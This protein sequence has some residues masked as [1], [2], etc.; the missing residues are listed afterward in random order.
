MLA[1]QEPATTRLL[2]SMVGELKL[3]AEARFALTEA[4]LREKCTVQAFFH[5]KDIHGWVR[6]VV[7]YVELLRAFKEWLIANESAAPMVPGVDPRQLQDLVRRAAVPGLEGWALPF[8]FDEVDRWDERTIASVMKRPLPPRLH[9]SLVK[10]LTSLCA[11]L[12]KARSQDRRLIVHPV[13]HPK[14]QALIDAVVEERHA[15]RTD[16]PLGIFD[17]DIDL[18]SSADG[19]RF[20]VI[21]DAEPDRLVVDLPVAGGWKDR[22]MQCTCGA[23]R[24][25]HRAAC[26]EMVVREAVKLEPVLLEAIAAPWERALATLTASPA[27]REEKPASLSI[28]FGGRGI[29]VLLHTIGKKGKKSKGKAIG[30]L[31]EHVLKLSGP[32]RRFAELMALHEAQHRPNTEFF[33]NALLSLAGHPDVRWADDEE[34]SLP[35]VVEAAHV[36]VTETE[37]G[38]RVRV[39]TGTEPLKPEDS[40][41]PATTGFVLVRKVEQ[42]V[43]LFVVPHEVHRVAR[44]LAVNGQDL[45]RE[46][47]PELSRALPRLEG[48]ARLELPEG[49]RGDEVQPV[50]KVV[51][52]IAGA[53]GALTLSVRAEPLGGG[54]LVVP[55]QGVPVTATFDGARRT[56]TRRDFAREIAEAS[57]VVSELG[58]DPTLATDFSWA[59]D[60]SDRNIETLRRLTQ[61]SQRGVGVEW[62][63][64]VVR[65]T[66]EA[67]LDK[68]ALRVVKKKDWFGLEGE[69]EVDGRRVDLAEVL[70]AARHRRK[71]VKLSTDDY[72]QLSESLIEQLT[73]VSMLAMNKDKTPQLTLGSLPLVSALA[74]QVDELE[75]AEEW[76]RL[77]QRLEAAKARPYPVPKALKASL[78][79]YQVEGF[80]WLSRLADWGAGACLA[81]DMGLGKTLQALTLLVARK[82][83]GP[84]LVV[85]PSSVLHTWLNEAANFAPSLKLSMFQETDRSLAKLK[86]GQ[87]VLVSW[88][89]F[90]REAEAFQAKRFA[91][92]VFD[93]AHA[94][95]NS[96][97]QR[98][99]AAHG[100]EADFVVALSG[101]PIENHVGELWSLFRAVMPSLFGSEESF[102]T[103]FASGSAE[104]MAGL[105]ALIRPFILRRSKAQVAKELPARTDLDV[106]VPLSNEERA[107]YDDVRL[108]TLAKIGESGV[109]SQRFDILAALTRLRLAACHPKLVDSKWAGPTSK[110]TRLLELVK[111]LTDA[112]HQVLVFS[113]FT[114]HL[115]LVQAAL[116]EEGVA[117]SYLDGQVPVGERAKRVEAF[118]RGA[119]GNVFLISLKAGGTGLT[120]TAADYVIHLDPWWNPAVEDQASDRAHRIG[121]TR[122][123]TVYR[124]IAEQTIEQ[125]ILSLHA[126]K[127]ELV[128]ALL[129]GTDAAGKL[130]TA[131]LVGLIR[132][133]GEAS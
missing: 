27:V 118:Q 60:G 84:A 15:M 129:A 16:Y 58:L 25:Y 90:A 131:Q 56:F 119:G 98:A 40:G 69:V 102:R 14:V 121:Q 32:D 9:Q 128:D 88:S 18:Y 126:E 120:L 49:L 123:V 107:L 37:L 68:V 130:T 21:W 45:P 46:A 30:R 47:L 34:Q 82:D 1:L 103:R 28:I 22:R 57:T 19:L 8:F 105:S 108:A 12:D 10:S 2:T 23:S 26:L 63:A 41:Y 75:S 4:G 85:A 7:S 65:F 109:E 112:G 122:P 54:A 116:R 3:P 117:Y 24:C 92:V 94:I 71:W 93:E 104:A 48:L 86:A 13:A 111:D 39:M 95:K 77:T 52:S 73:P 50:P 125:Q 124:L 66:E 79:D 67:K 5:R 81:D 6:Q 132:G 43:V 100:I 113:Q 115:A 29:V 59:L 20:T 101:T 78:R 87:V 53:P 99:K 17:A 35:C 83:A 74:E 110:L 96:N 44:S 64:P 55:G 38:V 97:T 51:V 114:S 36:S 89:V 70:E 76:A 72:A 106:V 33:G 80:R 62:K 133:A 31:A 61:V 127:R 42:R 91:T 11:E